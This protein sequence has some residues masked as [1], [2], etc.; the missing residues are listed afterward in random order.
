MNLLLIVSHKNLEAFLCPFISQLVERGIQF[1][2]FFTGEGVLNL[3]QSELIDLLKKSSSSVVCHQSWQKFFNK[4]SSP[5]NEGS[6]TNLS[7]MIADQV[8]VVSL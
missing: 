2:C 3:E 8:K 6:Q 5:I 1:Q 7:E 4:T